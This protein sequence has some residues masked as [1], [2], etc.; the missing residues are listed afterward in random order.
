MVLATLWTLEALASLPEEGQAAR[1]AELLR[2]ALLRL[3]KM[4]GGAVVMVVESSRTGGGG[5][6][7]GGRRRRHARQQWQQQQR[8]GKLEEA[9]AAGSAA[10]VVEGIASCIARTARGV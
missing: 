7:G 6:G 1:Q 8:E 5:G 10:G 4:A 9:A 3:G 2:G